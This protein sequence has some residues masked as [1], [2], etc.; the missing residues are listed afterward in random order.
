MSLFGGIF[1]DENY[2]TSSTTSNVE[3][4]R[5]VADGGAVG[6]SGDQT[7]VNVTDMGLVDK[8]FGYL[9]VADAANTDRLSLMLNASGGVLE[10]GTQQSAAVLDYKANAENPAQ[11]TMLYLAMAA[12]GLFLFTRFSQ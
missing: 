2:T 8:V 10:A 7:T 1:S 9:A 6:V 11:Q 12:A 5:V 4:K 3:D